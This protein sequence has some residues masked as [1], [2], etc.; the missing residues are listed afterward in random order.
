MTVTEARCPTGKRPYD[1]RIQAERAAA[2]ITVCAPLPKG[3]EKLPVNTYQCQYCGCWHWGHR[4]RDD[5]T[6]KGKEA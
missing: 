1:E 5:L 3:G 4:R 2:L 6:L